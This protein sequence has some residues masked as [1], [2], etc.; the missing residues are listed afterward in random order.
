M[1]QTTKKAALAASFAVLH[2]EL[3][4]ALYVAVLLTEALD[5]TRRIDDTLL[6]GVER[7]ASRADF[8]S[9][10]RLA[11][12]GACLECVAAAANDIDFGVFWMN[13]CFHFDSPAADGECGR[14][15]KGGIMAVVAKKSKCGP[16][17]AGGLLRCMN[18]CASGVSYRPHSGK[19]RD[20]HPAGQT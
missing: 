14:P 4:K 9:D 8:N 1:R 18:W 17:L 3:T 10:G 12:R 13:F 20:G 5:P 16:V 19:L 15:I 11:N 7:V 2:P 6:A